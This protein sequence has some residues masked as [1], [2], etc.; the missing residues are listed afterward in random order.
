MV[1][2]RLKQRQAPVDQNAIGPRFDH[3]ARPDA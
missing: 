2:A 3:E 1:N